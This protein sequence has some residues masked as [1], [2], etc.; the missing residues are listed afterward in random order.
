[1]N[2]YEYVYTIKSNMFFLKSPDRSQTPEQELPEVE[3]QEIEP[4]NQYEDIV[5]S[6]DKI[7]SS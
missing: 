6:V 4:E 3:E 1:M 5:L 2:L 7:S